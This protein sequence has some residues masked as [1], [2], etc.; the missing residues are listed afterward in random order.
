MTVGRRPRVPRCQH[1][2]RWKLVKATISEANQGT[3]LQNR[4]QRVWTC[5]EVCQPSWEEYAC[6]CVGYA[7]VG[8][9]R[10]GDACE[11]DTH[12]AAPLSSHH[13]GASALLFSFPLRPA[14]NKEEGKEVPSDQ[15]SSS[16]RQRSPLIILP[17]YFHTQVAPTIRNAGLRIWLIWTLVITGLLFPHPPPAQG[18]SPKQTETARGTASTTNARLPTHDAQRL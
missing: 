17:A 16:H 13:P 14:P 12:G 15:L 7:L 4:I 10:A 8:D 2:D 1:A 18:A 3:L 5:N 6:A 11:G 9:A